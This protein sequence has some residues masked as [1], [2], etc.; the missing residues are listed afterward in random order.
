MEYK[1]YLPS[2]KLKYLER[3]LGWCTMGVHHHI[4]VTIMNIAWNI[5]IRDTKYKLNTYILKKC[6]IKFT[7][8]LFPDIYQSHGEFQYQW[9]YNYNFYYL[10]LKKIYLP[11]VYC[12]CRAIAAWRSAASCCS[13]GDIFRRKKSLGKGPKSTYNFIYL[14]GWYSCILFLLVRSFCNSCYIL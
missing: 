8:M 4:H 12:C 11:T 5:C 6:S 9:Q 7:T 1:R 13:W 2:M 10:L 3:E 14:L